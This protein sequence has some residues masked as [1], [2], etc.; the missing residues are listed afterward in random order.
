MNF[1]RHARR[2]CVPSGTISTGSQGCISLK[3]PIMGERRAYVRF[4]HSG[5]IKKA[6][7]GSIMN[8]GLKLRHFCGFSEASS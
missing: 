7:H 4:I 6:L 5:G 1:P 8:R 3:E 2:K